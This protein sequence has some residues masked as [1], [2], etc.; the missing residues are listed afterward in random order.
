MSI[1]QAILCGIVYWLGVGNLPFVGLWSLQRPLVCGL[2][3]GC[4]LGDPVTGAVVGGTINIAYLGFMSAGGSMPSDMTIAGV[5]GTAYAITGGLDA[6]TALALAVPLGLLGTIV[7]YLRMTFDSIFVHMVDG[8]IEQERYD[9]IWMGNVLFPQMFCFAITVIPCTLAAYFGAA[10]IEG[11]VDML[12]GTVLSVFQLI[13]GL[14]PTL[15]IAITLQYIFKGEARVFLFVGWL[16]VAYT[17]L[18]LL[19]LGILALLVAIV[20]MQVTS[21][22]ESAAVAAVGAGAPDDFDDDEEF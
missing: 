21:V 6:S 1:L 14:M 18:D 17:G 5:L 19:P 4:I 7:W 2:I 9:K 10:Y 20:Y 11:L 16:L 15:G 8:W 3:T 13:G 12:S 22:N